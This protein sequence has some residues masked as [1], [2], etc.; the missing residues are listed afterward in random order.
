[1]RDVDDP[2][3]CG[4]IIDR[5]KDEFQE[6]AEKQQY[7]PGGIINTELVV[8]YSLIRHT[9]PDVFIESGTKYGYSSLFIAE[10]L[11]R[12]NTNSELYCL[13]IFEGDEYNTASRK[14]EGYKFAKIIEGPSEKTIDTIASKCANKRIGILIDGPKARSK[15]WHVLTEKI[16]D[17]FP[18]LLFICFDA[19][20][21]HTPFFFPDEASWDSKRSSNTERF[22]FQALFQ[23]I[24]KNKGYKMTMQSNQFCRKYYYL[25]NS[26]YEYRNKSWGSSFPW[27][28]YQVDRIKD[29][30]AHCYKLGTIYHPERC[31]IENG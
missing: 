9:K 24:Y 28:P 3:I 22:K 13:S 27:G 5:Y 21:E 15:S 31:D 30:I 2:F 26:I 17:S 16:S 6:F 11:Q 23:Q 7:Q 1:M 18:N 25:N 14:L 12:N 10:A 8:L 19:V 29:H 20:H 4:S